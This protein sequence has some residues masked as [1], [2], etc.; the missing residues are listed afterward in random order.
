MDRRPGRRGGEGGRGM[1]KATKNFPATLTDLQGLDTAMPFVHRRRPFETIGGTLARMMG[2]A[3]PNPLPTEATVR[4]AASL[5]ADPVSWGR[6]FLHCIS[7]AQ[8]EEVLQ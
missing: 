3:P 6:L 2:D 5:A 8:N 1:K 7:A 4:L